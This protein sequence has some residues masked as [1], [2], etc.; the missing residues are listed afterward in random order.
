[1]QFSLR[2]GSNLLLCPWQQHHASRPGRFR[3]VLTFLG[4]VRAWRWGGSRGSALPPDRTW[5]TWVRGMCLRLVIPIRQQ[6]QE[7][8]QTLQQLFWVVPSLL[9]LRKED[10]VGVLVKMP[11]YR[12]GDSTYVLT[13]ISGSYNLL[14]NSRGSWGKRGGFEWH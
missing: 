13:R 5:L 2:L 7:G 11:L 12:N 6:P 8:L 4:K 9:I 10:K 14:I 1:M 3:P